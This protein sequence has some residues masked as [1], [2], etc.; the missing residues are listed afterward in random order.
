MHWKATAIAYSGLGRQS[1]YGA[2][3]V[4]FVF[5][6]CIDDAAV[7]FI[8]HDLNQ[9]TIETGFSCFGPIGLFSTLI[10]RWEAHTGQ[11]INIHRLVQVEYFRPKSGIGLFTFSN[12]SLA[13]S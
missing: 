8:I 2:T 1:R 6:G 12:P 3:R 10:V 7:L 11:F 5:P 13:K 9:C 4:V